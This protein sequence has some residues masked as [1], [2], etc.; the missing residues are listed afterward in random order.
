[1]LSDSFIMLTQ[2]QQH[3]IYTTE[4]FVKNRLADDHS[5][6]DFAHIMRVVKLAKQIQQTEPDSDCFVVIMAA[7]LHDVID[8]KVMD[9]VITARQQLLEFMQLQSLCQTDID[10]IL[11]IIDNMSYSANLTEKKRLSLEG[12]IVQDADRLDAIGAIGIGRAFLYGGSKKHTMYDPDIKPR[13]SMTKADYR[14]PSTVINHF[15]EKLLHLKDQ[16]NTQEG[17]KL[18][19]TRHQFLV[20]FVNQFEAEWEC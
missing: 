2:S 1:M 15:Y 7:Y 14:T 8:D 10:A 19:L 3:C 6:H 16:M 11:A 9:N 18:A 17:Q 20:N 13:T 5:G 12:Q 4:N